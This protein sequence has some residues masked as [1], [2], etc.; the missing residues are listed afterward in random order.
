MMAGYFTSWTGA[1]GLFN[2]FS[3]VVSYLLLS[4][5]KL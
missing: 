3:G 4:T 2:T 1:I 5:E